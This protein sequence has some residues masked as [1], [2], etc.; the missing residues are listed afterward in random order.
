MASLALQVFITWDYYVQWVF[1]Y[2]TA[3]LFFYKIYQFSF[4]MEMFFFEA[5]V[6]L[7]L[8][9][10][11]FGRLFLG[12]RGNKTESWKVTFLYVLATLVTILGNFYFAR[13]QTYVI[14]V[15]YFLGFLCI[16]LGALQ[17]LLGIKAT[18]SFLQ[19]T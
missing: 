1:V 11:Q 16:G 15:E 3:V 14:I 17:V 12:S 18:I 6:F 5:L 2:L 13:M 4:P 19:I 9:L 7:L 10:V 8:V